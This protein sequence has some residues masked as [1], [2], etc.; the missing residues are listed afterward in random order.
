MGAVSKLLILVALAV[1]GAA[2]WFVYGVQPQ[3]AAAVR[4]VE[5]RVATRPLTVGTFL[6]D[7]S[8]PLVA[9]PEA[10][11][12]PEALAAAQPDFL[13]A[14]IV[15]PI[16]AGQTVTRAALLAPGQEGFLAAVLRPGQRAVSVAVDAV[17]GNAGH[18]FPGDH[19]DVLLT[20]QVDR[21]GGT[22]DPARAWASE[23]ILHNVR[24][25][26]VDQRLGSDIAHRSQPGDKPAAIAR[27][28][29]LEVSPDG[30]ETMAVARNIG[31]ISLTLRSLIVETAGSTSTEGPGDAE[32]RPTWA[33]DVSAVT[34][35]SVRPE[36]EPVAADVPAPA[37]PP[38]PAVRVMRG[39]EQSK[40]TQ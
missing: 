4:T 24:V 1:M 36:A 2:V 39:G 23:T 17:S 6:E 33:G 28:I 40:V 31:T 27:T 21:A 18:I 16:A 12:T 3:T 20:Q 19:V 14:V 38:P 11:A 30:A 7:G 26:A 22:A 8:A 13:G 32:R 15:A 35:A 34:R 29:T 10:N 5:V 37:P 9:I 25:I